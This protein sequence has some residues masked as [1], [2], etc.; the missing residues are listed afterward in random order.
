MSFVWRTG[1]SHD[2]ILEVTPLT[3]L[4]PRI[5]VTFVFTLGLVYL[6]LVIS[7]FR[8]YGDVM[9]KAWKRRIAEWGEISESAYAPS[10]HQRASSLASRAASPFVP[11]R[12][13]RSPSSFRAPLPP[14][15]P[16][17]P[18]SESSPLEPTSQ[19][20][21]EL[22]PS[23]AGLH[24]PDAPS[25]PDE[26]VGPKPFKTSKVMDLRFMNHV[27]YERPSIL[28]ERGITHEDWSR[29][30]F[31]TSTAWDGQHPRYQQELTHPGEVHVPR[32]PPQVTTARL[33]EW[34]N[35]HF[36]HSHDV[37]AI[38]CEE[39]TLEDPESPSHAIYILDMPRPSGNTAENS[40]GLAPRKGLAER[41]G[42][43]PDGLER[44]DVYDPVPYAAVLRPTRMGKTLIYA[45]PHEARVH[46]RSS[47]PS[48]PNSRWQS[49]ANAD[50]DDEVEGRSV[51]QDFPDNQPS[52]IH[53]RSAMRPIA[54]RSSEGSEPSDNEGA[55]V[56]DDEIS[57]DYGPNGD[58][59]RT[60]IIAVADHENIGSSS[61][62]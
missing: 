22:H 35:S 24:T 26:P 20:P 62:L 47:R 36:F 46:W 45:G 57:D 18:T 43:V 21:Q 11:H 23:Q 30:I 3:A 53:P 28:D 16:G 56:D 17:R 1:T 40:G 7:E 27:P 41:F 59:P 4:G 61:Q 5:G 13:P 33:I 6:A 54:T 37:E 25:S 39:H 12:P 14:E 8:R 52:H 32:P 55:V 50:S 34:W 9:D 60:D 2:T 31:D 44:I 51:I 10:I 19:P 29:F 15:I 38:L 42:S 49:I 48:L 58:E